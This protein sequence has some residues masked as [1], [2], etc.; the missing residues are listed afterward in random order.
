MGGG[1]ELRGSGSSGLALDG[2]GYHAESG[3]EKAEPR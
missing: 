1:F 3:G 2:P